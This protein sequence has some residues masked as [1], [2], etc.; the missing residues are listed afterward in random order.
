MKP[1]IGTEAVSGDLG[2]FK[3][4]RE[5]ALDGDT[6][7]VTLATIGVMGGVSAI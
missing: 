2:S 6:A 1:S 4:D 3:T 7:V 5:V